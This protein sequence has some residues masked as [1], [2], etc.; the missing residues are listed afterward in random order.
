MYLDLLSWHVLLQSDPLTRIIAGIAVPLGT[1]GA[2]LLFVSAYIWFRY[3]GQSAL[4]LLRQHIKRQKPPQAGN[5][6]V[7]VLTD[8]A[9]STE[10]WEWDSQIGEHE[11]SHEGYQGH[12][13]I[14]ASTCLAKV[15]DDVDP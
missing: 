3:G 5:Q 1:L 2:C 8:I 4:T 9:G 7:L 11:S 6:L 13:D 10:L 12:P 15:A 14:A